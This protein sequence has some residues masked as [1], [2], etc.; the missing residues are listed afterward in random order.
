[1]YCVQEVCGLTWSPHGNYLASGGN[2]NTVQLWDPAV[3]RPI[4]SIT[5]HLSAVKAVSWCPWQ[6]GVLAT[7]GGTI[8]R[9]I[10]STV[11]FFTPFLS[12]FLI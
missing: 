1:M 10:R 3:L 9:T 7:A 2:D 12:F 8:D 11:L 6:A 4:K 5:E